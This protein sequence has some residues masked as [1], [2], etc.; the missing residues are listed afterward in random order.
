MVAGTQKRTKIDSQTS[1]SNSSIDLTED[2]ASIT[3]DKFH[4]NDDDDEEDIMTFWESPILSPQSPTPPPIYNSVYGTSINYNNLLSNK[5]ELLCNNIVD[6]DQI[7]ATAAAAAAAAA[8]NSKP[9]SMKNGF[10]PNAA[11]TNGKI[12]GGG[13]TDENSFRSP[14]EVCCTIM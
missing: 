10:N 13:G 5:N 12:G 1:H 6:F 8:A 14:P 3:S 7:D 9:N 4:I 11:E 2:T